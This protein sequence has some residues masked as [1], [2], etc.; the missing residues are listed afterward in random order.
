M[1]SYCEYF[2]PIKSIDRWLLGEKLG[3]TEGLAF[4]IYE[5]WLYCD[6]L[7]IYGSDHVP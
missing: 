3:P 5:P 6:R 1:A 2:S 7:I 4:N